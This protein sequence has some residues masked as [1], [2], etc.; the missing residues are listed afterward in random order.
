MGLLTGSLRGILGTVDLPEEMFQLFPKPKKAKDS[1]IDAEFREIHEYEE[2]LD[3]IA[4]GHAPLAER[5]LRFAGWMGSLE[6]DRP[7]PPPIIEVWPRGGG[8]TTTF[9][10]G[11]ALVGKDLRR[12]FLLVVSRTQDQADAI[13]EAIGTIFETIGIDRRV[14]KYN[15]SRGWNAQRLS[16]SN[17]FSVL[18][19]GL[20]KAIRGIKIDFD[21]P[22]WIHLDDLDEFE[23]SPQMTTKLVRRLTKK[24]IP[25]RAKHCAISY[26]QNLI[27][28]D[29]VMGRLVSDEADFLENRIQPPIEKAIND[30]VTEAWEHEDG[31]T[32]HRIVSGTATWEGQSLEVCQAY[33]YDEGL[34]SFLEERQHELFATQGY[35]FDETKFRRYE[36]D[37]DFSSF[38]KLCR[39]WD[40]AATQGAGDFTAGVLIGIT[41]NGTIWVLDVVRA[42]LASNSAQRLL[43]MVTAWDNSR[44]PG[45]VTVH[46][47]QDPGSAGKRVAEEDKKALSAYPV[48][49]EK[50]SGKKA[51]RAEPFARD[52]NEGNVI[53][54]TDGRPRTEELDK[55]LAAMLKGTARDGKQLLW[56]K[57]FRREC[58]SFREDE[59]HDFDDQV[60]A[61]SDAH[62]RVKGGQDFNASAPDPATTPKPVWDF[63]PR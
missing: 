52:V 40:F 41:A 13:L 33:I 1:A 14:N 26:V 24:I 39:A 29:G 60:D 16:C 46:L 5:H 2:F 15:F 31:R 10:V 8:K 7:A 37:V 28:E 54:L 12:R 22:D 4:P 48:A 61:A 45:K 57:D 63:V 62:A 44:F 58:R 56:N 20:D 17:G 59:T 11:A 35:F 9:H 38:I 34:S 23:D 47:P 51:K 21:R 25:L 32:R 3:K 18:S 27:K 53:L 36:G 19:L 6:L 30:L 43:E 49:V 42:Q 50:M 55:F